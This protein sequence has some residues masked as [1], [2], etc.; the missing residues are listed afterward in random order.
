MLHQ[1]NEWVAIDQL[2]QGAQIYAETAQIL[3]G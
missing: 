2:E 3:L 1:P